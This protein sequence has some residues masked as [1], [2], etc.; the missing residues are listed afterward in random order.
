ML[1]GTI[2][3]FWCVIIPINFEKAQVVQYIYT[4]HS[5]SETFKRKNEEATVE[6]KG[7]FDKMEKSRQILI[8]LIARAS[9]PFMYFTLTSIP[10][11]SSF[12]LLAV[13][14]FTIPSAPFCLSP[15]FSL[16]LS[17]ILYYS[18]QFFRAL[19][20]DQRDNSRISNLS[21]FGGGK[22]ALTGFYDCNCN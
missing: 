19:A 5:G 13:S 17:L 2:T 22:R 1:H 16:L 7:C 12:P 20:A 9:T 4:N 14:P 15:T 6:T 3:T 10:S 21:P 8:A 11:L 18:D